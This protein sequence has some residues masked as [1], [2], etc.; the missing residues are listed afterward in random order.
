MRNKKCVL[1]IT[2]LV[3]GLISSLFFIYQFQNKLNNLTNQNLVLSE[4]NKKAKQINSENVAVISN[5]NVDIRKRDDIIESLPKLEEHMIQQLKTKG[6]KGDSQVIILDLIKHKELIP[7]EGV[8]GG[9]MKFDN[10]YVLTDQWVLA[11]INDG[12]IDGFML[13]KYDLSNGKILW[14][15]ISS[16]LN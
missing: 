15:V 16:Y 7:Y 11:S 1:G 4:E 5:L 10:I 8:L 12:H 14:Q 2:L 13:L 6:F 3:V 9:T